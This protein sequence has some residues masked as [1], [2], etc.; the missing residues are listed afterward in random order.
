MKK[1]VGM[2]ME[3][4]DCSDGGN[5]ELLMEKTTLM[6]ALLPVDLSLLVSS[7]N[8][9]IDKFIAGLSWAL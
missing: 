3:K 9:N 1:M 6:E 8:V 2:N 7:T 5:C 4:G